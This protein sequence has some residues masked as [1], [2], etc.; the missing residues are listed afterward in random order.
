MQGTKSIKFTNCGRRF[1]YTTSTNTVS[2]RG[3]NWLDADG[4]ISG[5]GTPTLIGSGLATASSWWR[6]DDQGECLLLSFSIVS[7][8]RSAI[9]TMSCPECTCSC[10]GRSSPIVIHQA[11]PRA[12][13]AARAHSAFLGH[14]TA[15]SGGERLLRKRERSSL[16]CCRVRQTSWIQ[17]QPGSERINRARPARHS[18]SGHCGTSG[19]VW[20]AAEARRGCAAR[21]EHFRG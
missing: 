7:T 11:E 9:L 21:P 4:S 1:K 2:A 17:V 6:V 3:Q 12:G 18:E 16:S 14:R 19:G 13:E 20:M 5:F 10:R 15:L 8:S